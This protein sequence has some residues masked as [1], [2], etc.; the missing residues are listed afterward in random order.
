MIDGFKERKEEVLRLYTEYLPFKEK[1]DDNI[2]RAKLDNKKRN[3]EDGKFILIVAG[4]AKSGKSTFIN[5]FLGIE[6]LPM[7]PRQCTSA[8]IEINYGGEIALEAVYADGRKKSISGEEAV[9]AFLAKHAALSDNYR[10]IPVTSIN[11]EILVKSKGRVKESEI[12]D[13]I[14]GVKDDNLYSLPQNEY[15]RLIRDYINEWQNKWQDI[16]TRISIAHPSLKDMREIT[17]IDSPGVNA[18]GRVGDITNQYIEKADAVIF[19]KPLTGQAAESSSFRNFLSSNALGR[20]KGAL[21]LVLTRKADLGEENVFTL[22][23][24]AADM[25]RRSIAEE[26]ITAVDSLLQLIFHKCQGKSGEEI[27]NILDQKAYD[28][29]L[30]QLCWLKAEKVRSEYLNLLQKKSNFPEVGAILEKFATKAHYVQFCDFLT[31]IGEGYETIQEKLKENLG[32]LQN[33]AEDPVK[34]KKE[35][36]IK[37]EE[38]ED[39]KLKMHEGIERVLREYTNHESGLVKLEAEKAFEDFKSGLSEATGFDEIEKKTLDGQDAFFDFQEKLR[40]QLIAD[41][42]EQ[43]IEITDKTSLPVATIIPR[44]SKDD[45]ESIK[46]ELESEA[47]EIKFEEEGCWIFK[48]TKEISVY[49]KEKHAEFTKKKIQDALENTKNLMVTSLHN[50]V[51]AITKNY[52]EKLKENI[53]KKSGEYAD[54]LHRMTRAEKI[55]GEM[56]II[57]TDLSVIRP[58]AEKIQ[59]IKG[60]IENVIG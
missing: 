18:A 48:T 24:Q 21:I 23:E 14:A 60:G 46:N 50:E 26:K 59:T 2:D 12:R 58:N 40:D 16:V 45:F 54:L 38:I 37:Q 57:E 35:I 52:Q 22:L 11:N 7:D 43:L 20:S 51:K 28:C 29:P 39:V 33:S 55:R 32:L 4:E 25:Y 42:N 34:L 47:N 9:R 15:D 8:L 56:K 5:A 53:E 3:I 13:L 31:M 49:S 19:V 36:D 44:L 41:C 27:N 17:I 10:K 30:A 1:Y 6:I